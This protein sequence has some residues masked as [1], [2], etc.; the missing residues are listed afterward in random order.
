MKKF[1]VIVGIWATI[2][3]SSSVAIA[4]D[5]NAL[6]LLNSALDALGGKEKIGSFKSIYFSASGTEN[7]TAVG[8]SY[9]PGRDTFTKHEEKLAV[10][11]DGVRLAYEYKTERGDG[12]TRW[13]RFMFA[14]GRRIVADFGTKAAYASAV[15]FPSIDRNEDARRI[16]HFLLLEVL[17]N[18]RSMHYA[19]QR[20]YENKPQELITVMLAN[21]RI[22][23]LLYFDKQTKLLTKY[24]YST[25][26]PGI[27]AAVI[28]YIFA[29]HKQ[30]PALAWFPSSQVIKVNAVT[31]RTVSVSQALADSGEAEAMMHLRT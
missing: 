23:L 25:D 10:F 1:A 20:T 9:D 8:Q 7:G 2:F 28:E 16:P 18:A 4:Q 15:K 17:A 6:R 30:H 22:L 3:F 14:D 31:Y 21:T 26:M 29:H 24:E 5:E 11:S 19:G 12:T 13:R 27:G